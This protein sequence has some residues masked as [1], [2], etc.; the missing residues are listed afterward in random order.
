MPPS[1]ETHKQH[2]LVQLQSGRSIQKVAASVGMSQSW[3]AHLRK[4]IVGEVEKQRGGRPRHLSARERRRC[5]TLLVEG[6]L[7]TTKKATIELR[8]ETGKNVCDIIVRRALR[9]EGLATH[10]QQ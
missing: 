4:E 10:V 7:G 6:C 5:V 9:G 8:K 1:S 2:A 3:V